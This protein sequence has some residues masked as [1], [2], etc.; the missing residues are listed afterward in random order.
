[1]SSKCLIEECI[2]QYKDSS[3][4]QEL[5]RI[6]GTEL[7]SKNNMIYHNKNH[8]LE[9]DEFTE[10]IMN[11]LKDK[12]KFCNMLKKCVRTA[13]I[14][15][16]VCHP[17]GTTNQAVHNKVIEYLNVKSNHMETK[18]AKIAEKVLRKT[19]SFLGLGKDLQEHY[20]NIVI[21]LI[22]ATDITTYF[23]EEDE[24]DDEDEQEEKE[25]IELCKLIIRCADL[26]HVTKSL[27]HHLVNVQALN[28]EMGFDISP[29]S[30]VEFITKYVL[31]LYTKLHT[32]CET[33]TSQIWLERIKD[34]IKYWEELDTTSYYDL[35]SDDS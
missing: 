1:M 19:D 16:D 10:T 31:P 7:M 26:S 13:A 5:L 3:K 34:K 4:S 22:L 29:K 27:D 23:V 2:D 25:D 9:V 6:I 30:N 20:I 21:E 24:Q 14:L 28:T 33:P 12:Y 11:E 15:H 8:V 18:H 32:Y 17:A 35:V